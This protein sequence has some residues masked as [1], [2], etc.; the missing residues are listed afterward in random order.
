MS[1]SQLKRLATGEL[2]NIQKLCEEV[3]EADKTATPGP[4]TLLFTDYDNLGWVNEIGGNGYEGEIKRCDAD[5]IT[6][7]RTAAPML[8]EQLL[9]STE[10]E[11]SL[12]KAVIQMQQEKT[13]I[14]SECSR[15]REALEKIISF[16]DSNFVANSEYD[17][18]LGHAYEALAD[19]ARA[20]LAEQ[21]GSKEEG[22][23]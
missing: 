18:G 5:F 9:A 12:A 14:Q 10:R 19:I 17:K 15:M 13:I 4:W 7:T 2:V 1:K 8:A 22:K 3:L 11:A 21:V 23:E 6:L 20:A 16:D